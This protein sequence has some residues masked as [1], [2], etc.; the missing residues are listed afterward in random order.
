MLMNGLDHDREPRG[1]GRIRSDPLTLGPITAAKKNI[2]QE[3]RE[4]V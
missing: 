1:G 2:E 4:R 3:K